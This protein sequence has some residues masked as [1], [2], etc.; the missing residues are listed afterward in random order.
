MQVQIKVNGIARSLAVPSGAS[1]LEVLRDQLNLTGT[2]FGCG[3]GACGSCYVLV[4]GKAQAAC[5]LM[6][7]DIH[8]KNIITVEGLAVDGVLSPVQRAFVIEDAMQ[9]GYC[10]SGMIISATAL[11][12][13]EPE[14][15]EQRIREVMAPH[16]CR[17]GIYQ[18]AIRAI[19]RASHERA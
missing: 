2:R 4:E 16:L 15:S 14:P 7:E 9:C 18:R 8:G 1:L 11:L 10:T 5:K 17:C 3:H 13:S 19:Q 6:A 12:A